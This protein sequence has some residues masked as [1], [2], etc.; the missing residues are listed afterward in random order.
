[1]LHRLFSS[2]PAR[3]LPAFLVHCAQ[4]LSSGATGLGLSLPLAADSRLLLCLPR[5]RLDGGRGTDSEA[6]LAK[7][8]LPLPGACTGGCCW[9]GDPTG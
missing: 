8:K 9:K 3:V 6:S 7:S 1:M 2:L 4:W 5:D